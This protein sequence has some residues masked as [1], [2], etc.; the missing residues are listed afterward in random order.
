MKLR[1]LAAGIKSWNLI[2][3][4]I[5]QA[6]VNAYYNSVSTALKNGAPISDSRFTEDRIYDPFIRYQNMIRNQ[7]VAVVG[8]F[9]YLE[10]LLQPV[11]ELF[12]LEQN[13][14]EGD[15]PYS[16]AE[17]ILPDC[18]YVFITCST[19]IDKSLPRFLKLAAQAY[20]VIVGPSTPLAPTLAQFGVKDLSSLII[21]DGD[22]ARRICSGQED[23]RIYSAGQKVS[24]Q[25]K[26]PDSIP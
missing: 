1:D 11:C 9:N 21:R 18:D 26:A 13:P 5:G 4:S 19:L 2:E 14:Q 6:A 17:Y 23:Y 10:Q 16:A 24:L 20:V 12:I 25:F 22:K 7:K 15:Y 8:H 3:A